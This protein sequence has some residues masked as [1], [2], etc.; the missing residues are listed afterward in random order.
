MSR[1]KPYH[2]H[3]ADNYP[4]QSSGLG[5]DEW[6]DGYTRPL[7]VNTNKPWSE[8]ELAIL[9]DA[10]EGRQGTPLDTALLLGRTYG[11]VCEKARKMGWVSD[12]GA[13]WL[14]FGWYDKADIS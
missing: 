4:G 9:Q 7:A 3:R 11:A 6:A 13:S 5:Y 12:F 2:K 14:P 10:S 1:L 8:T